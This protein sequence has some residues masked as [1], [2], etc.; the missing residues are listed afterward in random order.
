VRQLP[1]E[2]PWFR[3][4]SVKHFYGFTDEIWAGLDDYERARKRIFHREFNL[5]KGLSE[6]VSRKHYDAKKK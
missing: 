5:R 2:D 4:E 6:W 1:H 3:E